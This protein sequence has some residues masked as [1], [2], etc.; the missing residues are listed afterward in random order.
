MVKGFVGA[1]LTNVFVQALAPS[2][3]MIFLRQWEKTFALSIKQRDKDGKEINC[4]NC[5]RRSYW[6]TMK[7]K[8]S[9]QRKY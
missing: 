1:K 2:C 8:R 3:K 5:G 7:K 4:K 9:N 6:L